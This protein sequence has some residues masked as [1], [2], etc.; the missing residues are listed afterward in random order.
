MDRLS[1]LT[2]SDI[3][4]PDSRRRRVSGIDALKDTID[5]VLDLID[6]ALGLMEDRS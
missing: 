5:D 1:A 3:E 2:H 6:E 4:L